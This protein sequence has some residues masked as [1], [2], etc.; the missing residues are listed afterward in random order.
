MKKSF[1][2]GGFFKKEFLTVESDFCL[3]VESDFCLTVESESFFF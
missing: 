2:Q 3:T 1:L